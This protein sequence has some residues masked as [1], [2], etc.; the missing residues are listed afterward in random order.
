M[1]SQTQVFE[2]LDVDRWHFWGRLWNFQ[3]VGFGGNASW[4]VGFESLY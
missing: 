4:E 3:E 1:P 2:Y